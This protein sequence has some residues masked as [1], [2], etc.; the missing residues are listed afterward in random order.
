MKKQ[1]HPR[2][3][4][5]KKS[6]PPKPNHETPYLVAA[7]ACERVLREENVASAIRIFDVI[8]LEGQWDEFKP[9]IIKVTLLVI[10]KSGPAIGKRTIEIS[11]ETPSG[12]IKK[13]PESQELEFKGGSHGP[14]LTIDVG[15][16][17][18]ETGQYWFLFHLNRKLVTKYPLEVRYKKAGNKL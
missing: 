18:N 4:T 17:V 8:K 12:E 13:L 14:Q 10:F 2:K 16:E 9:G 5:K 6:A 7:F 15:L 11:L 3:A 1:P